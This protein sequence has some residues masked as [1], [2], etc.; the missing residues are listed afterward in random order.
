MSSSFDE[1]SSAV[2]E[3][4]SLNDKQKEAVLVNDRP[5]LIL[6]GAGSGKTR[7]I[8]SKIVYD[9]LV[10]DI[11]PHNILAVTFTNKAAEEMRTRL[12]LY[13]GE[14]RAKNV[15]I[16]TFHSFGANFLRLHANV[17]GLNPA[18]AIYDDKDAL[19]LLK[20][21][22]TD[23]PSKDLKPIIEK[24]LEAKERGFNVNNYMEYFDS[25]T[26]IYE[27][28]KVYDKLLR[29]SGNVDLPELISLPTKALSSNPELRQE[30]QLRY[31]RIFVDEYQDTN[32]AQ[33][34]LLKC[35]V[36]SGNII[37][38]VGDDDQSI[39]SFRG[40]EVEH[41]LE[42]TDYFKG[43]ATVKLEENYRSSGSIIAL[44]SS[45]IKHNKQRHDKTLW[46]GNPKGDLPR[47]VVFDTERDE[48]TFIASELKNSGE[49]ESVAVLYRTNAQGASFEDAFLNKRILYHVL[50]GN[51]FYER[52]DIKDVVALMALV[53]NSYDVVAFLRIA[54]KPA[55]ALGD[56]AQNTILDFA[57][58][59]CSGD[60]IEAL[61]T[62]KLTKKATEGALELALTIERARTRLGKEPNS[63]FLRTLLMESGLYAYYAAVDEKEGNTTD[64]HIDAL[65]ALCGQVDSFETGENG[66]IALMEQ[67]SL[68]SAQDTKTTEGVALSTVHGVKGLE[69]DRVY[70]TGLE[71]GL[72]PL[73]RSDSTEEERRLMYVAI[74][75]ARKNLTL[76][77]SLSRFK[78]G[79]REN[80]K[81][82][83]YIKE[84]DKQNYTLHNNSLKTND[85]IVAKL[86]NKN[87]ESSDY[88]SNYS[89]YNR[90]GYQNKN[91]Y[92]NS[93]KPYNS[94]SSSNNKQS[95]GEILARLKKASELENSGDYQK[96]P[97]SREVGTRE[98]ES[99]PFKTLD[100][101]E[102]PDPS[103][104]KGRIAR[105]RMLKDRYVMDV[106]FDN[107]RDSVFPVFNT[108]LR[109][110]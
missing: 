20:T 109:K 15:E 94:Y 29:E 14:N 51:S 101:V 89:S 46:T 83:P 27:Y 40:S 53:L 75:R 13:L 103:Y 68:V 50:R 24:I 58:L 7:T 37:C 22:Y 8:I 107:G 35:L 62:V 88:D 93:K 23:T 67:M 31:Q 71:D 19:A 90:Y 99:L 5:L 42:F 74:T 57:S 102:H 55:R 105:I 17:I 73:T 86:F 3:A 56:T 72:F 21:K 32:G 76:T 97:T 78:Y 49:N 1:K 2:L 84:L 70:I 11:D 100:R 81:P 10:L 95:G 104:G 38:V 77:L 48:A 87:T 45:L 59:Y 66:I 52:A 82:S 36:G 85:Q 43:A 25:H 33:F 61:K 18:F 106:H 110:I 54:N 12:T 41:I 64:L 47:L 108:K 34:A 60:L 91:L 6:A 44:A 9:I 92:Q 69:F 96:M 79:K 98:A 65:E 80:Q 16:R 63:D 4:L 28:F 26:D 30:T 39:Y